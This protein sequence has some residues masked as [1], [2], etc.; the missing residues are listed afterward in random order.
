[1]HFIELEFYYNNLNENGDNLSIQNEAKELKEIGNKY[2]KVNDFD[3]AEKY[4]KLAIE[5]FPRFKKKKKKI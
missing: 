1:M 4:Y 2:F 3:N 5:K